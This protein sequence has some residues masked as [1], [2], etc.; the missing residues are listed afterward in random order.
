[1]KN[2]FLYSILVYLFLLMGKVEVAYGQ[3]Y[4]TQEMIDSGKWGVFGEVVDV[5]TVTEI[6]LTKDIEMLG[7][8]RIAKGKTLTITSN[9]DVTIRNTGIAQDCDTKISSGRKRFFTVKSGGKLIIKGNENAKITIDGGANFTWDDYKLI[10]GD[11]SRNMAEALAN[12]GTM[13]LTNVIIQNVNGICNPNGG[14]IMVGDYSENGPTTLKNCVIQH[15][16]AE[17]GSAIMIA[18]QRKKGEGEINDPENCKITITDTTVKECVSGGGSSQNTGGT[19]R[20]YGASVSNL[21]LTRVSMTRNYA[22]DRKLNL[23]NTYE[24]EGNGGALF[25]NAHGNDEASVCKIDGCYF[26]YNKSESNGGAIKSQG[27]MEFVNSSTIIEYNQAPQ[28]AGLYIE[29]Y[30]GGSNNTTEASHIVVDLGDKLVLKNNQ[31]YYKDDSYSGKGGGVMFYFGNMNLAEKSSVTI[32]LV[33][34]NIEENEAYTY[35]GGLYFENEMPKNKG[36]KININL[37]YGSLKSNKATYGGGIYVSDGDVTSVEESGELLLIDNN[38]ASNSG[39]GIYIGNGT[40]KMSTTGKIVQNRATS[41]DGG[42]VYVGGNLTITNGT[43]GNNSANKGCGGGVYVNNGN[44]TIEQSG[45]ISANYAG[46]S[47]EGNGAGVYINGGNFSMNKGTINDNVVTQGNGGGVFINGGKL[48]F[49]NGSILGNKAGVSYHGNGGGICLLNGEVEISD[50]TISNNESGQYGGGLYVYNSEEDEQDASFTGGYIVKNKAQYGGG[51]CVN[52]NINLEIG[53]V[54]VDENTAINGGGICLL[55]GAK[56]DFGQGFI[57]ENKAATTDTWQGGTAYQKSI[58]EVKGIGGGVYLD[59]NTSLTFSVVNELGL[60]DNFADYGA[61]DVFANGYE[62]TVSYKN[63]DNVVNGLPVVRTMKLA[64]FAV[65]GEPYW[66]EDYIAGD[67]GYAYGI[68]K[69]KETDDVRRYRTSI[70]KLKEVYKVESDEDLQG[71]SQKYLCLAIGHDIVY[72]TVT[73]KGLAE[74]ESAIFTIE[75]VKDGNVVAGEKRTILL[76]GNGTDNVSKMVALSTGTWKVTE[77]DWTWAYLSTDANGKSITKTIANG[78]RFEFV[79]VKDTDLPLH[80]EAKVENS[81]EGVSSN[82]K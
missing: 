48:I 16:Y 20:S 47:E 51:V 27:S 62:T 32:N 21:Y 54:T 71:A 7:V 1:M 44:F 65:A 13:E 2:T 45:S 11:G 22:Q 10:S 55:N 39:G 43:I 73:K 40:F 19:I 81:M 74:G 61:D 46:T 57:R 59:S 60:Y 82:E 12:E 33:G 5:G 56:M 63:G 23:D 52:G 18:S 36:Y 72:V 42:G 70:Q 53:T 31:S 28:G 37:N 35:G 64:G 58:T 67:D 4:L 25:W 50:G 75:L 15:C 34:A 69:K 76:T 49:N 68:V 29:G 66:V 17:L 77:N 6:D 38:E 30:H 14:A 41:G 26:A 78:S 79:N 9:K 3:I 8:I 80:D 24:D